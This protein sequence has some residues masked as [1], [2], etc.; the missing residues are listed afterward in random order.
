MCE[1]GREFDDVDWLS[2]C[3][4]NMAVCTKSKKSFEFKG[5]DNNNGV[6]I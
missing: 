4:G 2:T 6:K 5:G 1:T 3:I